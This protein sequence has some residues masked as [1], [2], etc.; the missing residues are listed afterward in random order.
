MINGEYKPLELPSI[1]VIIYQLLGCMIIYDAM[2]YYNHRL[3]HTKLLYK[4]VHKSHHYWK[5]PV[6]ASTMDCHPIE[7]ILTST[8]PH[9]VGP[10][11]IQPNIF[12]AWFYYSLSMILAIN[13]HSGYYIPFLIDREKYHDYHHLK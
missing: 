5:N 10:F 7:H 4:R 12:V 2:F 9:I 1:P 3:L 13:D 11:L 8:L 6:A